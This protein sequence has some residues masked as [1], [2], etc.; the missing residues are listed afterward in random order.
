MTLFAKTGARACALS[1]IAII[2]GGAAF[3]QSCDWTPERAVTYVV[4]WGAGGGTDANSRMLASML[5]QKMG[6]PFNV[7]NRTGGNGVTGHS[8]IAMAA[9]DGYT[10]GAV[11]VEI[12]TMHWVGLT[13]LTYN[14]ITPIALVDIVPS[15]VLVGKDSPFKS[16][17]ELMAHARE[18]PGNL[19]ASG[20]SLGGIWHLALA[21]MLNAEG[22]DPEAIRWIPSQGAA[23]ALQELIAGGVDVA[24]PALS[25]GKAL[26]DSGEVRALAYM[27]NSPMA[28]L[29]DVP[30]TSEALDSGW[31]LAAYITMSG[32]GGMPENIACSYEQA[33]AEIVQTPEWAEFKASRGADVVSMS[34][35]DLTAFMEAQDAAL[36]DTI[37]AV[38]LAQ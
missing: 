15:S 32:P 35:A 16:L 20:T 18:N 4:P 13:D 28:A 12:N 34:A 24:T 8:A 5:E 36:G 7:V 6:V 14:D 1:V 17:D 30:L 33:V 2:G 23:P 22:M 19:T 10:V 29:P 31:T 21:G 26:V 3:A 25:E 9:P 27:H 11:T 37:K 38:G